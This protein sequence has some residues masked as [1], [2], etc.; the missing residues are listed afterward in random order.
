M[1]LIQ[2]VTTTVSPEYL[3]TFNNGW[4][5]GTVKCVE[6]NGEFAAFYESDQKLQKHEL[7]KI[8]YWVGKYCV[9]SFGY[10]IIEVDGKYVMVEMLLVMRS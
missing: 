4:E 1:S 5:V 10:A 2:Y 8:D 9:S 7:H 6:K 3:L